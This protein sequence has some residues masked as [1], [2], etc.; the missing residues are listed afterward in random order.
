MS[1]IK[2]FKDRQ[3]SAVF[4][5]MGTGLCAVFELDQQL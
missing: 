1:W 4:I 3:E 2:V 5:Y